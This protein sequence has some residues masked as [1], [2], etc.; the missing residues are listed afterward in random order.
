MIDSNITQLIRAVPA[1]SAQPQHLARRPAPSAASGLRP[2]ASSFLDSVFAL[3]SVGLVV[4]TV[5]F[6]I[7][8]F[9]LDLCAAWAGP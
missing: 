4:A 6:A 3:L 2:S 1:G 8:L 7:R 5:L 9:L